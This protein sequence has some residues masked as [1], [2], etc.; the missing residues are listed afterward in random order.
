MPTHQQLEE[1][2]GKAMAT[3]AR[4]EG[5]RGGTPNSNKLPEDSIEAKKRADTLLR[6]MQR[7]P[8]YSVRS[9]A[10][11]MNT[12]P[13]DVGRRMMHLLREGRV[14]LVGGIYEVTK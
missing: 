4:R 14:K 7:R 12:T 2:L 3:M 11:Y 5:H 13:A 1:K 9:L 10:A 6:A 8:K